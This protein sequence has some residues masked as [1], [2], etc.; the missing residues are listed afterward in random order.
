MKQG[1]GQLQG[2]LYGNERPRPPTRRRAGSVRALRRD[3]NVLLAGRSPAWLDVHGHAAAR[4]A[5]R[6]YPSARS[7]ARPA[8]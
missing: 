1:A 7:F 2:L 8:V 4:K 3:T 6:A 5:L